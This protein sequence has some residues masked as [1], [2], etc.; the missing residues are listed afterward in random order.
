MA[1]LEWSTSGGDLEQGFRIVGHLLPFYF[2][3]ARLHDVSF[4]T[5]KLLAVSQGVDNWQAGRVYRVAGFASLYCGDKEVADC[6]A[7]MA[8]VAE[9]PARAARLWGASAKIA[10][11]AG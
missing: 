1:A 7:G 6:L 9:D 2:Q 10:D 8:T 3:Q 5:G 4:W 11:E